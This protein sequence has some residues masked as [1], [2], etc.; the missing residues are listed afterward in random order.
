MS[1]TACVALLLLCGDFALAQ[2]FLAQ[3]RLHTHVALLEED[4]LPGTDF[5][6]LFEATAWLLETDQS[7][8]Y[9]MG[10]LTTS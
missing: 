5:L 10:M 7:L 6:H 8:W 3:N 2:A 1:Y 4:L 9:E